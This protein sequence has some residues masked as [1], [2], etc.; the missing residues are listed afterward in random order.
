MS[1][2]TN[3]CLIGLG[4]NKR[5]QRGGEESSF[6]R[7]NCLW[8]STWYMSSFHQMLAIVLVIVVTDEDDDA[9]AEHRA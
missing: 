3:K 7:R 6:L 9:C 5:D 8:H 2:D 1:E 4:E